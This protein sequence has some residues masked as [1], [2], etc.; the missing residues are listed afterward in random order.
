MAA[1]KNTEEL[2]QV[3]SELWDKI[4]ADTA[5]SAELLKAQLVVR[6]DYKE[7]KGSIT[8]DS[9]DGQEIKV[10]PGECDIKPLVE[11]SM[12]ADIAHE[13]WLG[14]LSVPMAI[15]TGKMIAKGPVNQALALLPAIKPAFAIYPQVYETSSARSSTPV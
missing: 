6:F 12:S 9:S 5:M 14:K 13:F 11:M 2:Q 15:L 10:Y 7:P 8:I 3:M 1:Y 4:K